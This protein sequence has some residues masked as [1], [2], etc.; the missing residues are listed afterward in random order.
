MK[1][2]IVTPAKPEAPPTYHDVRFTYDPARAAVWRVICG[3]L[4][5]FIDQKEPVLELG[6]GYGEFSRFIHATGKWA[7]DVN[8]GLVAYW[9][10]D[11]HAVVQSALDPLPLDPASV[12]TVFASNFFEHFSL[13]ECRAVLGQVRRVLKPGGRLVAVQPNFRLEPGRY[14]DDYTHVTPFTD[15]GFTDFLRSLG[16]RIAHCEPR[17]LPL[18]MKSSLPKWGWLVELY[19]ALP[20]RPRAGQFLVVAEAP[21]GPVEYVAR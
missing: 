14:F 21:T 19:L 18:T 20:W 7:L 15:C 13:A 1:P 12:A 6:A 4:Q 10:E 2:Q 16:W 8:P 9:P 3:Y 5:R 17:F 11:V